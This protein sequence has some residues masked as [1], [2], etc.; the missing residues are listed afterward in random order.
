[1][2]VWNARSST[3]LRFEY[4]VRNYPEHLRQTEFKGPESGTML[5]LL[6]NNTALPAL[7]SKV[8]QPH[9]LMSSD[10]RRFG[11]PRRAHP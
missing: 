1:M 11:S 10:L 3:S 9:L 6:T 4:P 2:V 8:A 7:A 5:A